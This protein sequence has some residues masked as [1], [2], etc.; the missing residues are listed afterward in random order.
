MLVFL[1]Q[2]VICLKCQMLCWLVPLYCS[3]TWEVAVAGEVRLRSSECRMIRMIRGW[4]HVNK[5]SNINLHQKSL[6]G[7][8]SS[9]FDACDRMSLFGYFLKIEVVRHYVKG[10]G[11]DNQV[12]YKNT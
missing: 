12:N 3:E 4:K 10:G 11:S 7:C 5:V 9:P 8:Q 6:H 1:R 2:W